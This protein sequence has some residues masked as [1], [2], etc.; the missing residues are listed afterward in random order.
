LRIGDQS[1]S[2]GSS[3]TTSVK[4]A[5]IDRHP[6]SEKTKGVEG[7]RKKERRIGG[8]ATRKTCYPEETQKW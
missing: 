4:K 7:G 6:Y 8:V 2:S 5:D 3:D 1:F